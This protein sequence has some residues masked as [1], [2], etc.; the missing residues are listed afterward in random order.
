M[1]GKAASATVVGRWDGGTAGETAACKTASQYLVARFGTGDLI[2][3]RQVARAL[4]QNNSLQ[5][6][7]VRAHSGA[8]H[9]LW[10][11]GI[12]QRTYCIISSRVKVPVSY[13]Y[14]LT[15]AGD[16]R[17]SDSQVH[18]QLAQNSQSKYHR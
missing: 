11:D 17:Q 7:R 5:T 3:S 13:L 14:N 1:A 18:S 4:D 9:A 16:N 12:L 10:N 15:F 6:C 8:N 2:D